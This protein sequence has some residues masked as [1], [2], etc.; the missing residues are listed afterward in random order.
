MLK[1]AQKLVRDKI[2]E[3]IE[4][5]GG[6]AKFRVLNDKEY[7]DEL[8][9]KLNEEIAEFK[10]DKNI[11]ELG[12]IY[13]VFE[14]IAKLYGYTMEEIQQQATRKERENGGFEKKIFLETWTPNKFLR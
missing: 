2:V 12:D 10:E 13:G 6:S 14:A 11:E 3:K 9:K 1:V 7:E 4:Q 8:F 5:K